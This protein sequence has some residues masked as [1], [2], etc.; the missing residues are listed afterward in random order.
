[1]FVNWLSY[2]VPKLSTILCSAGMMVPCVL[3]SRAVAHDV[4]EDAY[5]ETGC[6]YDT[7]SEAVKTC[8]M[9]MQ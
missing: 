6:E 2:N 3:P 4:T 1:M 7:I 5:Q 8:I 9:R